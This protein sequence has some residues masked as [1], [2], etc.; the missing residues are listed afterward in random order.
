MNGCLDNTLCE[1]CH[2]GT[3]KKVEEHIHFG[4]YLHRLVQS[5]WR[6][7]CDSRSTCFT[8]T[9]HSIHNTRAAHCNAVVATLCY[10]SNAGR[11]AANAAGL[12]GTVCCTCK[13]DTCLVMQARC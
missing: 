12:N 1:C 7:F 6:T 13:A 2:L 11:T 5:I 8:H 9:G 3:E 4:V 10:S